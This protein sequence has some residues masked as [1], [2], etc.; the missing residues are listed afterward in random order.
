M[1]DYHIEQIPGKKITWPAQER[2][3]FGEAELL[4]LA[5]TI[6][7]HGILEPIG[8]IEDGDGYRGLWGQ[9]RW[10]AAEL[11]SLELIPAVVRDKPTTEAEAMEIRL[12]ENMAREALRPLEQAVGLDQLI[13][14]S[15]L[16]ASDLA[17][18]VGMKPAAVTKSLS[19]LQLS[20]PIRQQ[21]DAGLISPA[22]GYELAR[23]EDPQLRSELAAQVAGGTLTRDALIG[24]IKAIKRP[25]A[26]ATETEKSRITAKL[27][28]GRLVTVCG[29][30]LTVD[31]VITALE[32]LLARCRAARTKGLALRT[33]LN[34]LAD[35]AKQSS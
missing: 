33:M 18:R 20:E 24:R 17:K 8:V 2:K 4:E 25:G 32:D 3:H 16:S 27:S 34:V 14:A 9:R 28:K 6:R 7:A 11:A 35:E 21:I 10:M 15:G 19:L 1:L 22:A 13:K 31:S 29:S 5:A 30:N 12:I 23:V 26:Q